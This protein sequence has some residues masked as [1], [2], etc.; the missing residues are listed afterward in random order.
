MKTLE[1][2]AQEKGE[3]LHQ[4]AK[5][6]GNNPPPSAEEMSEQK[7]KFYIRKC[8][9]K[10]DFLNHMEMYLQTNPNEEFIQKEYNRLKNRVELIMQRAPEN[11]QDLKEYIAK[12]GL[13]DTQVKLKTLYYLLN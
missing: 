5:L 2:V 11:K 7:R 10:I 1:H 6:T 13:I 9:Q 4:L 8:K 12:T 3:I